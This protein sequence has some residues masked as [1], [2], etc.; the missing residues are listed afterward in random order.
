VKVEVEMAVVEEMGM[1]EEVQLPQTNA[2][3][4]LIA[5]EEQLLK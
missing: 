1:T 4:K 2:K 5:L 3:D